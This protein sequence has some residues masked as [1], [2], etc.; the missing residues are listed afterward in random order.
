MENEMLNEEHKWFSEK[1]VCEYLGC[2]E[3][4]LKGLVAKKLIP[5][6]KLPN[7]DQLRF[8]SKRLDEWLISL[9]TYSI[10]EQKGLTEGDS[11]SEESFSKE[12]FKL[13]EERG[14]TKKERSRYTNY[15]I[16]L[17]VK[18]QLHEVKTGGIA[19]AIPEANYLTKYENLS[20]VNNIEDLVG[21][22]GANS[23]WLEGNLKRFTKE[24]A[25]AFLLPEDMYQN[26]DHPAWSDISDII[27]KIL[28]R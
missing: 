3:S 17:K 26:P 11:A 21:Y 12:V 25:K 8:S 14:F 10:Q 2:E 13:F 1:G 9:E 22:W 6:S 23:D 24:K 18:A 7:S 4:Y 15:Y 28:N 5:Y 16:G 19:L 27:T 20:V